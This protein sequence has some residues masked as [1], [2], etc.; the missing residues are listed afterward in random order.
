MRFAA[1]GDPGREAWDTTHPV[2]I[3]GDGRP[4]TAYGPRD[5]ELA[6][7]TSGGADSAPGRAGG[8]PVR[9]TELRSVVRRL[10]RSGGVPE[11]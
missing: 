3:F 5:P 2:R 9:A 6:L 4:Y 7:W 11:R 10:R 1:E 8:P